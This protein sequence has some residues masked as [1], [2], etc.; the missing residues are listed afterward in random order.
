MAKYRVF[1]VERLVH[2]YVVEADNEEELEEMVGDLN[3]EDLITT[4]C[5]E[6][7]LDHFRLLEEE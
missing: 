1:M 6:Y 7:G 4:E 5:L 2:I 3:E